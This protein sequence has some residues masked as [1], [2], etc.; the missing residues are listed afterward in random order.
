M[1]ASGGAD[2]TVSDIEFLGVNA[3]TTPADISTAWTLTATDAASVI[4]ISDA[5]PASNAVLDSL[6]VSGAGDVNIGT[7][8]ALGANIDI[9]AIDAAAHTGSFTFVGTSINAAMTAQ[10]GNAASGEFNT[11]T[12]GSGNDVITGGSGNDIITGGAGADV[13]SGGG[14]ADTI[15]GGD[16]QDG[17]TLGNDTAADDV[18]LTND[19]AGNDSDISGF[20][21]A[22]DQ[23]IFDES[24]FA[25]INFAATAA[26]GDLAAAD[27]NEAAAAAMTFTADHVNIITDAGGFANFD[28]AFAAS[29]AGGGA[30]EAFIGFL[31]ST[32][33]KFELYFDATINSDADE[34]L[35]ASVDITGVNVASLSEANFGVL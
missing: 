24:E 15:T 4:T 31:N 30:D 35:V 9:N 7:G 10:L 20:V 12:A 5:A 29:T 23:I 14:G 11:F 8:T 27:Y 6:V 21:I 17:I 1:T 13:I 25:T 19:A 26:A 33:G 3:A 16:G 32:S 34:V 18:V 28:A 22:N 2:I